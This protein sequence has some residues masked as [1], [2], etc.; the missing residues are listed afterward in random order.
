MRTAQT[1][2]LNATHQNQLA[3]RL[4]ELPEDRAFVKIKRLID[5]E[6]KVGLKLANRVIHSVKLLEELLSDGLPVSN[7]TTVRY[8]LESLGPRLGIDRT[9]GIIEEQDDPERKIAARAV[10]WLP[11]VFKDDPIARQKI[12]KMKQVPRSVRSA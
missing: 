4:R 9:L 7:E 8:W 12:E 10:Y 3:K 11:S 5:I 1:R 6:P 2:L